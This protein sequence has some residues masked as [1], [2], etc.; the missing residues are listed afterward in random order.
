[1]SQRK[2]VRQ[3]IPSKQP[4]MA[5]SV[6]W[7]PRNGFHF[8][9]VLGGILIL[10]GIG[11]IAFISISAFDREKSIRKSIENDIR[12][13]R[14]SEAEAGY[15]KLA[16]RKKGALSAQDRLDWATA[17]L[18]GDHPGA[19]LHVLQEWV[20]KSSDTP[21]GWIIMLDLLR[22][23]G[24]GDRIIEAHDQILSNQVAR[25]SPTVL[26]TLTLGLLTDLEPEQL[27]QRLQKWVAAEPGEAIAQ[28]ALLQR[29]NENPLPE[30]PSRDDRLQVCMNLLD[31]FPTSIETRIAFVELLLTS[32]QYDEAGEALKQWPAQVKESISHQRLLGRYLQD[33]LQDHEN[34]ILS[35]Q[36]VLKKATFDW[37]TRYRLARA[38]KAAGQAE[39]AMTESARMLEIREL[40][41][42][43]RLEPIIRQAFPKGKPPEPKQLVE[44]LDKIGLNA[45][46]DAWRIW[47]NDQNR[48]KLDRK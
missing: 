41:E 31:R 38:L 3:P 16:D 7:Q 10:L 14:Y 1:M 34:A 22:V 13:N 30:D 43:N 21:E 33:N 32:G 24:L 25:R 11:L 12:R 19:A 9:Y 17:A 46:A 40:L 6:Q 23:L 39:K 18:R 4:E 29:Y 26:M 44:L 45:L 36:N 5:E 35:F 48:F 2:K 8:K 42:P 27:R 47:L 20:E 37:K 15:R 28:A